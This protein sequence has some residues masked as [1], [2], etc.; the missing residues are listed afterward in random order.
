MTKLPRKVSRSSLVKKADRAA[1]LYVRARDKACVQCGKRDSLT[2]GHLITRASFSVRWDERNL[3]TQCVGCNM[4]HEWRPHL[5][6]DW[7]IQRFGVETYHQLVIDSKKL[8][9]FTR[10]DLVE[11]EERFTKKLLDI[12]QSLL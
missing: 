11:I 10:S 9:K 12:G 3:F 6:T 2:C 4:L 1:S 7:Y 5:F 8:S